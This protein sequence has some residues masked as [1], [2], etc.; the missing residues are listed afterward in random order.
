MKINYDFLLKDGFLKI[1]RIFS[2][3]LIG[4]S[5]LVSVLAQ[6]EA[7]TTINFQGYLEEK[8]GNIL[9]P[10]NNSRSIVFSLYTAE[11]GGTAIWTST[12][13]VTVNN[14]VYSVVLG[15]TVALTS[16]NFDVPY[17]LGI[18]V[19]G[20]GEMSPRQPL[21]AAA[22]AIQAKKTEKIGTLTANKWCSTDGTVINCTENAP[23]AGGPDLTA[24]ENIT[25]NWVNTTNPWA[26]NEVADNLTLSGGTINNS[27]IGGTTA[28]AGDF[29]II[30]S[31]NGASAGTLVLEEPSGAGS[32]T[33][34]IQTPA[35]TAAYTLTLPADDGT[36]NQMLSTN[37]SGVLS[38][39]TAGGASQLTD[40]S[41]VNTATN[42]A[43]NLLVAD[44]TDFE[45]VAMSGDA[46][47]DSTGTVTLAANAVDSGK[48]AA[49]TIS[50]T[51]LS[52]ILTFADTDM[53]NLSAINASDTSEGLILPQAADVSAATAEGQISWDSD[54]DTLYVGDGAAAKAIS[55]VGV[56]IGSDVQAHDA[57]LDTIAGLTCA[58]G[59]ILKKSSGNWACADASSGGSAAAYFSGSVLDI[60]TGNSAVYITPNGFIGNANDNEAYVNS[61]SPITCSAKN[62]YIK[63]DANATSNI[64]ATLR[65]NGS[66]TALTC[67]VSSGSASCSDTSNAVSLTAGDKISLQF[68]SGSGG[69]FDSESSNFAWTCE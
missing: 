43:G 13:T 64:T 38:W 17:Y 58:D 22:Y 48:I 10:V 19:N 41:D 28:A 52:G 31:N 20:D 36:A 4:G 40:L 5:L 25:G 18:N 26:D 67:T 65:K 60:G 14:G 63:T 46:T 45:S 15:D 1:K 6:A 24:A 59:K 11:S 66:N 54:N 39:A 8:V 61:L 50:T 55:G 35:D 44:G 16:L 23:S 7:P 62:L 51:D 37:G 68:T 29:T 49:D 32:D 9:T 42:T 57:D 27:A 12:K 34:T 53:I 33:I 56:T 3:L 69:N 47:M 21:T 2:G 30:T